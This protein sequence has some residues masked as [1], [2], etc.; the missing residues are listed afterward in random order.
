MFVVF[1]HLIF[2]SN[3]I[4]KYKKVQKNPISIGVWHYCDICYQA[5]MLKFVEYRYF[6]YQWLLSYYFQYFHPNQ[7]KLREGIK[8]HVLRG[9]IAWK[10]TGNICCTNSLIHHIY[11]KILQPHSTATPF[12]HKKTHFLF[13]F[14]QDV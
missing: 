5:N 2:G 12:C 13:I 7:I 9:K 4:S 10:L 11:T 8:K 3:S 1:I 14:S 6:W